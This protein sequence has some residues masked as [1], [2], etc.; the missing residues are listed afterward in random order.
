M[1]GIWD[2]VQAER[3][4]AHAKHGEE[5]MEALDV[6]DLKRLAILMEE[7]GEVAHA[8]TYDGYLSELRS[9]LVQVS[10]MA[11]AWA[12]AI[13]LAEFPQRYVLGLP[14]GSALCPT[15]GPTRAEQHPRKPAVTRCANCKEWLNTHPV[16]CP[17]CA[18]GKTVNCVGQ[19][20]HPDSD[21]LVA[22]GSPR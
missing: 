19:A 11:G 8:L 3:D 5:S 1:S 9:E 12:D 18:Q 17:E 10:A 4:R 16:L 2:E 21:D 6:T 13:S 7:V 20:M 22:C 15:C 14:E